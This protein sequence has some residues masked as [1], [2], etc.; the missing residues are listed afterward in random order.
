[1]NL[2]TLHHNDIDTKNIFFL[3]TK[4]NMIIDGIFTKLIYTHSYYT[5]NGLYFHLPDEIQLESLNNSEERFFQ[6]GGSGNSFMNIYIDFKNKTHKNWSIS[7]EKI[8]KDILYAYSIFKRNSGTDQFKSQPNY[9]LQKQL[10]NGFFKTYKEHI[11]STT[12]NS[13]YILKISGIWETSNEY[14]ITYKI[15]RGTPI[16]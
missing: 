11:L 16:L 3:E 9:L 12:L 14:G 7:V 2:I 15:I 1:M 10:K 8:E 4:K 13:S 6:N 5:M